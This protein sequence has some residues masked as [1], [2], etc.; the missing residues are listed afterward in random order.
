MTT[1][2]QG[3]E[4]KNKMNWTSLKFINF[5]LQGSISRNSTENPKKERK[6][7]QTPHLMQDLY[8]E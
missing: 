4:E 8:T 3:T 2:A 7:L 6:K 5:V 1:K